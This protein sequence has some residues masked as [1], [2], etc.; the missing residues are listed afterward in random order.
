[1][2]LNHATIVEIAERDRNFVDLRRRFRTTNTRTVGLTATRSAL[3][4]HSEKAAKVEGKTATT[5]SKRHTISAREA[6]TKRA[7]LWRAAPLTLHIPR[8]VIYLPLSVI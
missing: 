5:A 2:D 8:H 6:A 4:K 7:T 1:L 3:A